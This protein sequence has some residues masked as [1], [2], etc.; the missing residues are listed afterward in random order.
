[1]TVQSTSRRRYVSSDGGPAATLLRLIGVADYRTLALTGWPDMLTRPGCGPLEVS[2]LQCCPTGYS[3]RVS[4][5]LERP[6]AEYRAWVELVHGAALFHDAP[7]Q[8]TQPDLSHQVVDQ[9]A[10]GEPARAAGR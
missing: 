3:L 9:L 8:H 6:P 5:R 2:C 1:M 7:E 4:Y 10:L